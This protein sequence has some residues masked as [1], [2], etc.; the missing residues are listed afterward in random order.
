MKR[1]I[2]L[3]LLGVLFLTSCE[4]LFS[5]APE[6]L[7][8]VEQMYTDARYAQGFIVNAYRYIPSYYDNSD[9]ATDDAVTNQKSNSYLKMATG[10]WSALN[11]PMDQWSNSYAAIQ[12]INLFLESAD[13]VYWADD[14][15]AANLFRLRMT[16]EAYGL[17]ALFMYYLLRSHA[18]FTSDGKL[19]GVPVITKYLDAKSDFN[20]PRNT[21]QE[22]VDQINKDLDSA[23]VH[24]PMEYADVANTSAIPDKFKKYTNTFATYNRVMGA[25]S[26]QLLNGLICASIRAR[27]A[28]LAASPAFTDPSNTTTWENAANYA[29]KIITY[30]GGVTGLATNGATFFANTAE[31]DGLTAGNNPNEMIWRE[32][33]ATNNS[34]QENQNFPPSLFGSGYMNPSQ[35]LVDAFPMLNGYPISDNVNSGYDAANPYVNRDPRLKNYIIYNGSTAGVLSSVILTG[36]LSGTDNG[37]NVKETSTRTGYYMKKRL[38]MDVNRNPSSITG[39]THYFPRMRYTEMF[40]IYAEAA[41]E[42]W[43]PTGTGTNAFSAYDVIKAIRKRAGIGLTNGDLYLESCKANQTLMRELIRNE[44][45]LELCFESF[46]FWDVRRWKLNLNEAVKGVD[47]NGTQITPITVENRSYED[48][49]NYGPIPFTELLK[50]NKLVQNKGWK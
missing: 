32:N 50:Y 37:I 2:F 49:M 21:F 17:R 30:K 15:E 4:D 41:N 28:L 29:A 14:K 45:R 27:V 24:L 7:K 43:G 33:L 42:A 23:D 47:I 20:I 10:S 35:N 46:R 31:I 38:R 39:K 16:G 36:S 40:L 18:G 6:N 11:N 12:Y 9:Y 19:L 48:Y 26:K 8:N 34:E 3:I 25:A 44:R 13:K 1:N 5:P 22:C